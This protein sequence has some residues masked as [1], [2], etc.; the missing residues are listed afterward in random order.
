MCGRPRWHRTWPHVC[1]R[2]P[3]CRIPSGP[4]NSF[5]LHKLLKAHQWDIFSAQWVTQSQNCHVLPA[6]STAPDVHEP[7]AVSTL[8]WNHCFTVDWLLESVMSSVGGGGLYSNKK[9]IKAKRIRDVKTWT[10]ISVMRNYLWRN[11]WIVCI[12][13]RGLVCA[14]SNNVEEVWLMTA[15]SPQ[16]VICDIDFYIQSVIQPHRADSS[17]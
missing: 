2:G 9:L 15:A 8:Q 10:Y 16:V 4:Q 3:K 12:R 14:P 13:L 11:C 17:V 7:V 6:I 5:V 1:S